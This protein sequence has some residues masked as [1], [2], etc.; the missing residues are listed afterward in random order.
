MTSN[1]FSSGYSAHVEMQLL[2]PG[3]EMLPV[4]QSGPDFVILEKPVLRPPSTAELVIEVDGSV[5]RYPCF[6]A[7]GISGGRI[8]V[9]RQPEPR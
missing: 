9:A 5:S 4:A 2:L 3:G 8:A 7:N 1:S 6:L